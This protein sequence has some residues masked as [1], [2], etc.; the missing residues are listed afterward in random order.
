MTAGKITGWWIVVDT[1]DE[2][3]EVGSFTTKDEA[4]EYAED[5]MLPVYKIVPGNSTAPQHS[6]IPFIQERTR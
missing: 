6:L 2:S 1:W 5:A 3:R 4:I